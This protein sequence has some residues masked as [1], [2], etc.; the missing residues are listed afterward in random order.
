[1]WNVAS[2]SLSG[3]DHSQLHHI[4]SVYA[5][6]PLSW[7]FSPLA[8]PTTLQASLLSIVTIIDNKRQGQEHT[9]DELAY[10]VKGATDNTI[11]DY[12]L[13]AWLMAVC[14]NGFKC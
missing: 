6:Q 10:L 7:S 8:M 11:P 14:L 5:K 1:M 4:S 13:S 2:T 3:Q 9:A 12:Q